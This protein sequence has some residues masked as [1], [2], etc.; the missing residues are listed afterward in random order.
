[1]KRVCKG[2][3]FVLVYLDDIVVFS[4]SQVE[5]EQHLCKEMEVSRAEKLYAKMSKCS[6]CEPSVVFLGHVAI[7][8]GVHVDPRKIESVD[9]WPLPKSATEVRSLLGLGKYFKHFV[10][11]YSSLVRLVSLTRPKMP[12]L[13]GKLAQ[14]AFDALKH[15]LCHAPVLALPDVDAHYE[16]VCDSS[17][18]GS[19]AVLLQNQ[20]PIAFHSYK[21]SDAKR[22]YPGNERS[23]CSGG[24]TLRVLLVALQW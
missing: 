5:H 16:V 12:F 15:D 24:A 19:G 23:C 22:C 20:K 3:D 4:K 17:G 9:Q 13:W 14:S 1:M 2:L 8:D 10:E 7:S 6:F 11:G 21:L 18:F